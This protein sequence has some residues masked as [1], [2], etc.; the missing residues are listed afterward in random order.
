MSTEPPSPSSLAPPFTG[1]DRTEPGPIGLAL[2]AD[3]QN[4]R[5][6]EAGFFRRLSLIGTA[7]HLAGELQG[8]LGRRQRG[9]RQNIGVKSWY[10]GTREKLA[11]G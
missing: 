7:I 2:V 8:Q 4:N 9:V 5:G 1:P 10:R 3:R 11:R 6:L